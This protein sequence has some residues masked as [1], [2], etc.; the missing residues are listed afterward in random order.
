MSAQF[1]NASGNGNFRNMN[2]GLTNAPGQTGMKPAGWNANGSGNGMPS[3]K[4]FQLQLSNASASDVSNVDVFGASQYLYG[5]SGGGTW[6]ANGN[7]TLNGITISIISGG[8]NYQQFLSSTLT[9]VFTAGL[10]YLKSVAG[11]TA[12]VSDTY[13]L[14]SVSQTGSS[15]S[16]PI[17][18]F[19]DPYQYIAGITVNNNV[20]NIDGLTKL[21]W[22]TVYA[23]A[24]FQLQIFPAQVV[25]IGGVLNGNNAQ[26]VN[27][28]PRVIGSLR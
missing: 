26:Q 24:V 7:F 10:V 12:Q 18:P 28:A 5:N 4:P 6:S 2:G 14:N 27:G 11:N 20:F 3:A 19:V 17:T 21:T 9:N 25:N 1:A 23:S 22:Q 15:F 8:L 13:Q 16:E